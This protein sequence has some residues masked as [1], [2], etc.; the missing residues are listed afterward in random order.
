MVLHL[1]LC[2]TSFF[3][4]VSDATE[5]LINNWFA[6]FQCLHLSPPRSWSWRHPWSRP[7]RS[8]R[9]DRSWWR[10]S[11]SRSTWCRKCSEGTGWSRE[12]WREVKVDEFC[13]QLTRRKLTRWLQQAWRSDWLQW[14]CRGTSLWTCVHCVTNAPLLLLRS[15]S[16]TIFT[17]L[18]VN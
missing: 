13:S 2:L 7:S 8:Q 10:S 17:C 4:L 12:N 9:R 3:E 16:S 5:M 15:L 11:R 14:P 6:N 18:S 1:E